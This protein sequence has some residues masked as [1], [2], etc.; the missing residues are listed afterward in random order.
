M[1]VA[2][3]T[4]VAKETSMRRPCCERQARNRKRERE[5]DRETQREAERE[6][7]RY[8]ARQEK[9]ETFQ[10]SAFVK[11]RIHMPAQSHVTQFSLLDCACKALGDDMCCDTLS[12][13][14]SN[15][16]T[17]VSCVKSDEGMDASVKEASKCTQQQ[18][19]C[20]ALPGHQLL[21]LRS[22]RA[23]SCSG[24]LS[25]LLQMTCLWHES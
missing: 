8:R 25:A 18:Q 13:I 9:R 5:R 19:S 15:S 22:T 14:L 6:T 2:L 12:E 11:L 3:T 10:Q 7:E 20:L 17:H 1:K 23:R 24:K 16:R 21:A 4:I